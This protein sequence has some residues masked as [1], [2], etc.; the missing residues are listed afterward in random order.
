MALWSQI[1]RSKGACE[2]CGRKLGLNAHHIVGRRNLTLRY[3]PRNGCCLCS[4]C[5]RLYKESAHEDPIWFMQWMMQHRPDDY[6][7]LFEKREELSYNQDYEK[8]INQL[9]CLLK[10]KV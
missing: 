2:V 7:Y 6:N 4:G 8:V 9:E 3:D 5:H 10:E 1:V